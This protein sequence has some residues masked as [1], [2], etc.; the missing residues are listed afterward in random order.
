MSTSSKV[1]RW[2]TTLPVGKSTV[3]ARKAWVSSAV[4]FVDGLG[5]KPTAKANYLALVKAFAEAKHAT[6]SWQLCAADQ[7][8]VAE[9]TLYA[10]ITVLHRGGLLLRVTS[11]R[12][13]FYV[14]AV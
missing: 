10:A 3:K 5:L 14:A 2:S 1:D 6:N 13:H 9:G 11:G 4:S 12:S 8:N 7:L